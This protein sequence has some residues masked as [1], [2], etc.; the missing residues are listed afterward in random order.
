MPTA[1]PG[2]RDEGNTLQLPYRNPQRKEHMNITNSTI[3][4]TLA[5]AALA[6]PV[7]QAGPKNTPPG[8]GQKSTSTQTQGNSGKP[9]NQNASDKQQGTKTTTTTETGP[10]G[11]LKNNKNPDGTTHETMSTTGPG[12]SDHQA[13]PTSFQTGSHILRN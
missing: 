4:A 9:A 1:V 2:V 10:K 12:K 7:S 3:A 8:F 6:V 13:G 5:A 11:A